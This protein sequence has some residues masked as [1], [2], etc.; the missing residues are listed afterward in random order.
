MILG[1]YVAERPVGSFSIEQLSQQLML[2]T[3]P[4][5]LMIKYHRSLSVKKIKNVLHDG[6]RKNT[7]DPEWLAIQDELSSFLEQLDQDIKD[8]DILELVWIP[9]EPHRLGVTFRGKRKFSEHSGLFMTTLWSI[10][11]GQ[12]AVVERASLFRYLEN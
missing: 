1:N 4:R 9:D 12:H 11:F 6:F 5:M 7:S 8:G 3:A 2:S 10:W